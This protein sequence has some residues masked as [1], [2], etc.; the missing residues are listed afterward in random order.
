[1]QIDANHESFKNIAPLVSRL[2]RQSFVEDEA[3]SVREI[4][5]LKSF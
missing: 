4:K 1:M 3:A 2:D 5:L